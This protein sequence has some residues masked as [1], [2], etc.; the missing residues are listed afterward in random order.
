MINEEKLD[1][2]LLELGHN[3]FNRGTA[4]LRTAVRFWDARPGQ[5]LTK[6]LYPAV[7]KYHGT[8]GPRVERNIRHSIE[9]AWLRCDWKTQNKWFGGSVSPDKGK[10]TV[11]EYVARLARICHYGLEVGD[12]ERNI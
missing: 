7:G 3:D 2:L 6:E 5:P 8:T 10:P 4:Q 9:Q 1:N 11:G 12:C